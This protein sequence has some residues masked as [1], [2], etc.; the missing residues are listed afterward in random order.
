MSARA[1]NA[2][3]FSDSKVLYRNR[4]PAKAT[5][6]RYRPGALTGMVPVGARLQELAASASP[7]PPPCYG[8]RT[9]GWGRV[10]QCY[11]F[12]AGISGEPRP[13]WRS[14]IFLQILQ[15]WD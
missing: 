5:V 13:Y 15:K 6:T 14:T 8:Y 12:V 4:Q 2:G 9:S 10:Y 7:P 1:R 11:L 3:G